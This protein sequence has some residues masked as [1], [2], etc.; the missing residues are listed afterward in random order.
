M[1]LLET[2]AVLP[3]LDHE[4]ETVILGVEPEDIESMSLELS[5]PVVAAVEPLIE[6]VL[7]ELGR[8]GAPPR[9]KGADEDVSCHPC[10]DHRN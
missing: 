6:G 7:A 3:A 8:L 10:E 2:L 4:P 5:P 9:K 1:D